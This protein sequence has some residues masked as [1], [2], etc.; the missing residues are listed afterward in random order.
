MKTKLII[1]TLALVIA[2]ATAYGQSDNRIDSAVYVIT[3]QLM[4][5]PQEKIYLHTD[6][7]YYI[8][9]EKLFFR[10]FLLDAYSNQPAMRSRYVYVEL[11]NPVDSVVE[12][13]KIRPDSTGLFYGA[14]PLSEDLPQATYQLRAYTQY[15]RN[16]GESS[17]FSKPVQISDPQIL[18]IQTES[19]FQ[20]DGD[21]KVN[22]GLRFIH[23]KTGEA[24]P[25]LPV[26]LRLNHDPSFVQKTSKDGWIRVKLPLSS[27]ATARTLYV[28]AIDNK[29]VFKQYLQI[30]Y[31]EGAFDVSF[32]PEGGQLIVGQPSNVAFKALNSDGAGV[33]ITG[34]IIDSK[35][36][37]VSEF[38]TVYDGMGQFIMNPLPG[39]HYKA[40]CR[41]D[42]SQR[43]F[44]LPEAQTNALALKAIYRDNKVRLA[45][46][47]PASASLPELYLLI[48]SRGSVVY[49]KA[50][51][52]SNDV[53]T[54]DESIFPSGISHILLLT[55]DFQTVSERL[56]FLL[57]DDNGV[58]TF[59]TQ[60]DSYHKRESVEA[61]IQLKDGDDQPLKGNFS[62]AVTNDKEVMTDT[63]FTIL[64][65]ILLRS[66]L[67]GHIENP[68][69][70]F[71]KGNKDAELAADLL[72]KTHGW[73]RYD[74]PKALRGELSEPKIPFETSQTI[75][76]M[77]KSGLLSKPAKN[78]KLMLVSIDAGFYDATETDRNGRYTF[79]NFEFPDST[80]YF[81]QAL[82]TKEEGKYMTELK[83]DTATF[84]GIET[85]CTSTGL[86]EEKSNPVL[87]DY[88]AKLDLYYTYENGK[89]IIN[90]PEVEVK[91]VYKKKNE[92]QPYSYSEPDYSVTADD[93]ER[94]GGN[95]VTNLLYTI[96]GW[97]A[98]KALKGPDTRVGISSPSS[99]QNA[100]LPLLLIDG[101]ARGYANRETL[102]SINIKEIG[103][104]DVIQQAGRLAFFGSRGSNGVISI[105]TKKGQSHSIPPALNIRSV[106]PLGYQLPVEFYSPQYD[107][108]EKIDDPKPDL[109]TTIDW[110]PNV[111][112][113]DTGH[114]NVDFYTSDDAA[115]Y[116]VVIEGVS[117]EGKLVHYY[118]KASITVK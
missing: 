76:G 28:E 84:P 69:F 106:A 91:T 67:K 22:A 86:L 20:F 26:T 116:S 89:R 11:I 88:V 63:T 96:P 117:D 109:R 49:A 66:E 5:F 31:P 48:H 107:T 2:T 4:L 35:G 37:V 27:T 1:Q 115:S 114:A 52:A 99:E 13:L 9:G 81:I 43:T 17:F 82:N 3:Q 10:A 24:I 54:L 90:L 7:P 53:L 94:F 101:V 77:V 34:E 113:D 42:D 15:M 112:T 47:R 55:K 25:S 85:T 59:Q 33:D 16:Q 73:T 38:K 118:G 75:T 93:I 103:Q 60:K 21:K 65:E 29:N 92:N 23:A 61:G 45:I 105:I 6:K 41:Y 64:S 108:Q 111:L 95:D 58:A 44:D 56:V 51:D 50:W 87:L 70:Y 30:P 19:D 40:I 14:I 83:I 102:S 32:Y 97:V 71:Q 57:N 46:N 12:R 39:E 80:E 98:R 36:D 79:S 110:K 74:I 18:S 8:T 72:M 78:F 104:L 100:G 62:I 68:A